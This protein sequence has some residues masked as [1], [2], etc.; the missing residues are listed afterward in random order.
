MSHEEA[1]T[2]RRK[3]RKKK[4]KIKTKFFT[5]SLCV[6]LLIIQFLIIL[7]KFHSIRICAVCVSCCC[8]SRRHLSSN[9]LLERLNDSEMYVWWRVEDLCCRENT[10]RQTV[11]GDNDDIWENENVDWIWICI[12]WQLSFFIIATESASEKNKLMENIF[13]LC[14]LLQRMM[15]AV[16]LILRHK[17]IV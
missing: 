4:M 3:K 16:K 6:C 14:W 15:S 12:I 1:R 11:E 10:Q 9:K 13:I 7:W 5:S 8:S 2:E 17:S